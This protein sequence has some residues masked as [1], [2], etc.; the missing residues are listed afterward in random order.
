MQGTEIFKNI[1]YETDV[2]VEQ[3]LSITE[4]KLIKLSLFIYFYFLQP[5]ISDIN[6]N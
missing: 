3:I 2:L 6:Q 5:I 4:L 1:L